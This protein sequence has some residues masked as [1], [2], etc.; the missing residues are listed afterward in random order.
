MDKI[1]AKSAFVFESGV[2]TS[3][4]LKQVHLAKEKI[5]ADLRPEALSLV[6]SFGWDDNSL[7]SAIGCAD[8]KPYERLLEWTKKYNR[9]NQPESRK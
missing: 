9:V 6:E 2:I 5:L 4:T 3:Q 1:L 7:H 8:G